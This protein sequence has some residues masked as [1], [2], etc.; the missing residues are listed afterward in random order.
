MSWGWRVPF[1]GSILLLGLGVY[2]R[3]KVSE[4]PVFEAARAKRPPL[5]LPALEA[6]R[7]SPRN[8]LV[9]V[10]ARLAENA[11]GYLYP[12]FGLSY[13]ISTLHV[14]RETAITAVICGNVA[15]VCGLGVL[16]LAVRPHRPPPGLFWAIMQI[17]VIDIVKKKKK[18]KKKKKPAGLD[19]H[20]DR[21][22]GRYRNHDRRRS[23]R[24]RR[25][26]TSHRGRWRSS[27]PIIRPPKCWHWR[28]WC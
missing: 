3:A 19:Y 11:L 7:R 22:G 21:H 13:L 25:S 6:V 24:L 27:W 26:C 15:L 18:K 28:S 16:R 5:K 8:F 4:T 23:D 20:R 1:L 10:G 14:P 12:V 9:V 2:I 17:I